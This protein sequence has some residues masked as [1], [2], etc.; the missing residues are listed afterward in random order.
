QQSSGQ[1]SS[2]S[3]S[4][5]SKYDV[6]WS[7]VGASSPTTATCPTGVG[8]WVV[9]LKADPSCT[10]AALM[11]YFYTSKTAQEPSRT[12]NFAVT[13]KNGTADVAVPAI[14]DSESYADVYEAHCVLRN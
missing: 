14:N 12:K 11:M 10:N 6:S 9:R 1:Q 7:F 2:G 5:T 4:A 8:C 13:L 3:G